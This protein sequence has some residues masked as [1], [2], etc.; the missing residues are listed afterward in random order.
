[1]AELNIAVRLDAIPGDLRRPVIL[2]RALSA[3]AR[4]GAS[5]VELCG[6]TAIRPSELSDTGLRQLRKRLSDLDLR[7]A[8]VRFPTRR[9]YDTPEDLDRRVEATKSAMRMAYR[10]GAPC[11]INQIGRVPDPGEVQIDSRNEPGDDETD[12]DGGFLGAQQSAE[13]QRWQTLR[14][15]LDDLGRYGAR[16]GA[17]LAAETGSEPG[18]WLAR[19]LD[20]SD[21]AFVGVALNPGQLIVN[22]HSVPDAIV[23]LRDRVQVV[24]AVDGVLDLAAGRGLS[25]PLGQGTAD[26]PQIIGLLEDVQFRG[27][28]VVGRPA[29]AATA[30]AT[31]SK[32]P[33]SPSDAALNELRQGIEYLLHM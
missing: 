4:V 11:V 19:I 26:F 22:R 14:T 1:M 21:E 33:S 15:V 28:F 25:V 31:A 29:G 16:V 9:G 10:L 2:Q 30:R 20:T 17:F 24:A 6:R 32:V 13:A 8:S 3:A 23:A 12:G 7:V 5:G 27:P 18:S